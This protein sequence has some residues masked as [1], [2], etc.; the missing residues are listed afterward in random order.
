M[1]YDPIWFGIVIIVLVEAAMI[2][3]PVGVNL[4]IVHGVRGGG[5]LGEVIVG[6]SPFVIAMVVLIAL[7]IATTAGFRD[8]LEI[9]RQKRPDLSSLLHRRGA[10]WPAFTPP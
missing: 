2:T 10:R 5:N 3:P 4:Y 8:L 1:G 6:A 9:G 7:L